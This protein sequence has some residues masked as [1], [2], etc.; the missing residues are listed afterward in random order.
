VSDRSVNKL[1]IANRGEI[2]CRI[3]RTARRLGIHTIAVFSEPDRGALHVQMADDAV[4]LGPAPPRE[5][6]RLRARPLCRCSRAPT[7][8]RTRPTR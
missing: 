3:I 8:S 1:L 4:R 6:L 7:R 2:A 5:S